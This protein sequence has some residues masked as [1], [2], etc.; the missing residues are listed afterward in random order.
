MMH[1]ARILLAAVPLLLPAFGQP[2]GAAAATGNPVVYHSPDGLGTPA[3]VT[4]WAIAAADGTELRLFVDYENDGEH[5]PSSSSGTMCVSKDGDE[6]CGFD[7]L[8]TMTTSPE[9]VDSKFSNFMAAGPGI[10]GMIDPA[11]SRTLRVNGIDVNGMPMPAPIGTLVVDAA[12]ANQI[13]I[14]VEGRHRVGA[15]G[16]MDG[17]Q[18]RVIA[19]PEPGALWLQASGITAVAIL[20]HRRQRRCTQR[21]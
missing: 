6:T 8:I 7:V 20:A 14:K 10:V 2:A 11:T 15:A 4:P 18:E 13:Q 16:Q 1:S 19:M 9:D 12:Q 17:I 3:S 21:A 5:D